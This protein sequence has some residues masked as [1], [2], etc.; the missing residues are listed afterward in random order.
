[1]AENISL[2]ELNGKIRNILSEAFPEHLWV[3]AEIN[4]LKVNK[5]GHCYLE[6]IEKDKLTEEIKAKARATIWSY[7]FRL[8]KPYFETT[9]GRS[10]SA[11]L[12]VLLFVKIEFHELYGYSLNVQDIDPTYTIGDLALQRKETIEKLKA[13]GVFGMNKDLYLPELPS[14]IAVISSETAAG[15][16]DFIQQLNTNPDGYIFYTKL[17]PSIMQGNDAVDSIT[18]TLDKIFQYESF[19]DAVVIIR[20][21]GSQTDLSC[22]DNYRLANHIAQFPLPVITGIGHDKDESVTD[23][24]A[25]ISLKTPTAVAEFLIS[26]Y[27]D[28]ENELDGMYN[29][30][31]EQGKIILENNKMLL[32]QISIQLI[33]LVQN[34]IT[35]QM[36][37]INQL[38]G[39]IKWDTDL[40]LQAKNNNVQKRLTSLQFHVKNQFL[41]NSVELNSLKKNLTYLSASLFDSEYHKLKSINHSA[42]LLNPNNVLNR[43]YSLTYSSGRIVRS[44]AR[45]KPGHMITTK[46]WYGKVNSTIKKIIL[47]ENNKNTSTGT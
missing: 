12:K 36:R 24:V 6:L 7:T 16:Q 35:L 47:E 27:M 5:S 26:R 17:F 18:L 13:D 46:F 45:L 10:F 42:E 37:L 15:Y 20:G 39:R 19:F 22:F 23:L 33:P 32:Q 38:S 14:K 41:K 3:V 11:G 28:A 2:H 21:G 25:N 44:A 1:L 34:S 4:E 30:I 31:M 8:L 43:G 9:T 40:F 29:R